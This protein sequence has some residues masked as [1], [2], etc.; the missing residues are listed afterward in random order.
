[1]AGALRLRVL[2]WTV[3]GVLGLQGLALALLS[4]TGADAAVPA[5]L[6]VGLGLG[7]AGG[8][9]LFLIPRSVV[10]GGWALAASLAVAAGIHL[11][12]GRPPP[13]S[14]LVNLAAIAAVGAAPRTAARRGPPH[15]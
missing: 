9:I 7:E 6:R 3:A 12:L 2:H 4:A 14:S 1:M 5:A 13:I 10:A 15:G 8:A 11:S